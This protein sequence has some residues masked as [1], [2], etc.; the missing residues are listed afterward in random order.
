MLKKINKLISVLFLTGLLVVT[1]GIPSPSF[2]QDALLN[3]T[4]TQV[5]STPDFTPT[6]DP[7]ATPTPE[8][9]TIISTGNA[10]SEANIDTQVNS[11]VSPPPDPTSTPTAAPDSV[12]SDVAPTVPTT[13]TSELTPTLTPESTPTPTQSPSLVVNDVGVTTVG[14]AQATTGDNSVADPEANVQITTGSALAYAN[15]INLINTNLLNSQLGLYIV[16]DFS[17][18]WANLDLNGIWSNLVTGSGVSLIQPGLSGQTVLLIS[19]YNLARLNNHITV[20]ANTGQNQVEGGNH[21]L[22]VTGDATALANVVNLVNTNL[23]NSQLFIGVV[24]I[25]ADNLGDIILP[26]PS[27]FSSPNNSSSSSD[28][29][30]NQVADIN[31]TASTQANSGDNSTSTSG[32]STIT[33]SAAYALTNQANLANLSP[34]NQMLFL[35]NVLG[36]PS[37]SIYNR[38]FPGSVEP[39]LANQLLLLLSQFGCSSCFPGQSTLGINQAYINNQVN[40]MANTGNN[41]V[42]DASTSILQTGNAT[43]IANI[44]NLANLNFNDSRWFWTITNIIGN[45]KGNVI[46]AYPDLFVNITGSLTRGTLGDIQTFKVDLANLGHDPALGTTLEL[47]LPPQMVYLGDDSGLTPIVNGSKI[48]WHLDRF[49]AKSTRTFNLTTRI[50][51]LGDTTDF[52]AETRVAISNQ[53]SESDLQNNH[54]RWATIIWYPL[55]TADNSS[56]STSSSSNSGDSSS[57]QGQPALRVDAANN[58]NDFIL[59]NDVVTFEINVKNI[60]DRKIK[61]AVLVHQ[62]YDQADQL[63]SEDTIF[64][65]DIDVSVGGLVNFGIPM[66]DASGKYR[67]RSWVVGYD[68]LNREVVSPVAET[69]FMVKQIVQL[70]RGEVLAAD[71]DTLGRYQFLPR[72][73]SPTSRLP[74]FLLFLLSVAYISRQIKIWRIPKK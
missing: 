72:P 7:T 64:L 11:N 45:W 19:P 35:L 17:N 27:S 68:E 13:P 61:D 16:N 74:S 71:S 34:E 55:V 28:S 26:N 33:T 69:S 39:I 25:A 24:N 3:E 51:S 9:D 54:S 15:V 58:V 66:V 70:R 56:A 12:P 59:P 53:S 2:A 37:G 40:V 65:G 10:V 36:T 50:D 8:P 18:E 1:F 20:M 6:P 44:L 67:T 21:V 30:I 47:D 46:Y 62:I 38:L 5:V 32:S 23:I 14:T 29:S 49:Q 63:W 31:S 43:A 22:I 73:S 60:G 4:Q 57:Y 42:A 41:Q 52:E 48:V